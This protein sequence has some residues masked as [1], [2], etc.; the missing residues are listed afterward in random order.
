MD[1]APQHRTS[2][3]QEFLVPEQQTIASVLSGVD[4]LNYYMIFLLG[5][6]LHIGFTTMKTPHLTYC[7]AKGLE[8]PEMYACPFWFS[9]ILIAGVFIIVSA[10]E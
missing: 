2:I 3:A 6:G 1:N 10:E 8:Y 4:A 5:L 7:H 9:I